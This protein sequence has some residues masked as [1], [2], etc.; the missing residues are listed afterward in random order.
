MKAQNGYI[1]V[2]L[3]QV[4]IVY[5]YYV[6]YLTLSAKIEESSS[7]L[8]LFLLY[9]FITALACTCHVACTIIN[10]GVFSEELS[11]KYSQTLCGRCLRIRIS[12]SHHCSKCNVCVYRMDH[13]CPWINSCV[14]Y[15]NQKQYILFLIYTGLFCFLAACFILWSKV[16]CAL[17]YENFC[18][19]QEAYFVDLK[20]LLAL[21]IAIFFLVFVTYLLYEQYESLASGKTQVDRLKD[22]NKTTN[23][24]FWKNYNEVFGQ[25]GLIYSILPIKSV[26]SLEKVLENKVN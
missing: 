3:T 5:I 24:S 2:G 11:K 14:G 18:Q 26:D 9:S 10:P 4:L 6:V 16:H 20:K 15:A 19:A 17:N 23:E 13:H 12:Q 25:Q 8:I 21:G 1:V 22:S 7:W